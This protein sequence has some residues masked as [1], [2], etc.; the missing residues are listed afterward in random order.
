MESAPLTTDRNRAPIPAL[1]AIGIA[2]LCIVSACST[3]APAPPREVETQAPGEAISEAERW[4]R[5]VA[6][7]SAADNWEARGKVAYRLPGD[8]GSASLI[9]HQAGAASTVR[10][11]GPLGVGS[12]EI[13]NA[14]ALIGVRRDG[15][16]RLYPA[17]A[18]PWLPDGSL[19][20]I[21]VEALRY[22]LRGL[23][24]PTAASSEL[25]RENALASELR[26]AGWIV[27]FEAFDRGLAHP[28]PTRLRIE[29]PEAGLV[30]RV[31]IRDWQFGS[32][33]S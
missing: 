7:L 18:A 16:E 15:I 1:F 14:G 8:G 2:A 13:R 10:V 9:W 20:P 23:P 25:E 26:Q 5:H 12:T 4:R 17:D 32:E 33:D 3:T 28:L 30:L 27:R 11:S 24:D 22:W 6:A 19:L 29:A 21:P 31:L